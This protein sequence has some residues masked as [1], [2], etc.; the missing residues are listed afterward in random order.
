MDVATS[1]TIMSAITDD[2][3]RPTLDDLVGLSAAAVPV[4]VLRAIASSG[5]LADDLA[6]ALWAREDLYGRSLEQLLP[7]LSGAPEPGPAYRV[8]VRAHNALRRHGR[9]TWPELASATPL[10][11]STIPNLGAKTFIEIIRMTLVSW[12]QLGLTPGL[13]AV[14]VELASESSS[15]E[16][17]IPHENDDRIDREADARQARALALRSDIR[18]VS[19]MAWEAG[20]RTLREALE[21]LSA[22]ELS[23]P[24][25]DAFERLLELE[26]ADVANVSEPDETAWAHLLA[27]PPRERAILE[28]RVFPA[29]G[30]RRTLAELASE[31]EITRERVRQLETRA[32]E[33]IE[34]RLHQDS[35]PPIRHLAARLARQIGHVAEPG[36]ATSLAEEAARQSSDIGHPDIAFRARILMSLAGPHVEVAGLL[37]DQR[38]EQALAVAQNAVTAMEPGTVVP[39]AMLEGLW[40]DLAAPPE[41]RPRLIA[42]LN[43]RMLDDQH[44]VW[45][46]SLNDKAVAVLSLRG[47]PMSPE[48]IHEAV[49]YD[50]NPRSLLTAVQADPR[51]MRRGKERYGLRIWGGEEYTG[52][53]EEIEQAIDRAG[54]RVNLEELV[55]RFVEDFG[56]S[57]QS[58]RSYASD[59]RFVR[60]PSGW[61]RLRGPDDPDVVYERQQPLDSC[62]GVFLRDGYW[63][64][65][66][67]V[68]FEVLRGSGRPLRRPIAHAIG[69]EPDLTLGFDYDGTVVTFSW[70]SHPAESRFAAWRRRRARLRRGRPAV[71]APRRP[72]APPLSCRPRRRPPPRDGHP[73]P[74]TGRRRRPG[75]RRRRL[76]VRRR[77]RARSATRRRLDR[78]QRP[79]QRARRPRCGE[80]PVDLALTSSVAT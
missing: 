69:L 53:L 40:A 79:P 35:G 63:N 31:W 28:G 19:T 17:S 3:L 7:G 22:G 14:P 46:G 30:R 33:L 78:H 60:E 18:G 55:E 6:H 77:R 52:I 8:S 42:H 44:I 10:V 71:P 34:S 54:G 20:A 21:I 65:R 11:I 49:G 39:A 76:A 23:R 4:S 68:G 73:S 64:L 12:A 72:R 41:T 29:D 57:A 70:S 67:L 32:R 50:A 25:Q 47:E 37:L 58:V 15:D 38:G 61:L 2:S 9:A 66:V 13:R 48:D 27:L 56:V 59:R 62:P 80:R 45:R 16:Q 36:R 5:P 51:I 1:L 75:H 24:A 43:L 26:L 74:R